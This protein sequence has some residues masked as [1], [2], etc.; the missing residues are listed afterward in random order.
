MM[1]KEL[2]EKEYLLIKAKSSLPQH[3][4]CWHSALEKVKSSCENLNDHEHSLLALRLANCFL[5]DSGHVSYNCYL[6]STDDERRKCINTMS[7]RAFGVYNEFYTHTVHM[8]FFF[9]YEA[10]QSETDNTIR[11]LYQVSSRMKEQLLEASEMQGAVLEG[12]RE[13]LKIQNELLE[14]G[15]ELGSVLKSSSETVNSMILDFKESA[16]D[17]KELLYEIFSYIRTFQNWV[18]GE[19]SWFQSIMYY[20]GSCILCALFSSLKRTVDARLTLFAILSLNVVVE[21]MLVQYYDNINHGSME[22]KENLLNTT[23]LYRKISLMLCTL[24]LVC[25][26]YCYKDE[27]IET[28]KAL[29]RIEHHLTDIQKVTSNYTEDNS[30][31]YS[32]R[33]RLKKAEANLTK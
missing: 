26:Y 14:N 2:G 7:D 16:K 25:T 21:R 5:E 15:R 29:Q 11:L 22:S 28:Y 23:W 32:K 33:L 6:S 4:A 9:N 27:Q 1:L 18:I 3:G 31:R 19:V 12:Q 8:C 17:Q 20:T 10:W 24:T 13:G 30:I